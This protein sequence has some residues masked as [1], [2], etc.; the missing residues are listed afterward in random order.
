MR[1]HSVEQN[2]RKKCLRCLS[3]LKI[4]SQKYLCLTFCI[5]WQNVRVLLM[6]VSQFGPRGSWSRA[7]VSIMGDAINMLVIFFPCYG[8]Q[9][10]L[11]SIDSNPAK[12]S[13]SQE[14]SFLDHVQCQK[15]VQACPA[16]YEPIDR[17][18]CRAAAKRLTVECFCRQ[19]YLLN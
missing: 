11:W 2:N 14:S 13:R 4:Y 10:A 9:V 3:V 7:D 15:N 12:F 8:L 17:K 5:W 19:L 1:V 16:S 18:T 6:F